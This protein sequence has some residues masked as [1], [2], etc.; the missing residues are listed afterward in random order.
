M[1]LALA[2]D[3]AAGECRF[4]LMLPGRANSAGRL[5]APHLGGSGAGV[6]DAAGAIDG[7]VAARLAAGDGAVT[8]ALSV[9]RLARKNSGNT[10]H[11]ARNATN[12]IPPPV[13]AASRP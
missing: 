1:P 4:E 10:S 9:R 7:Q 8:G 11:S 3:V 12:A 5:S 13:N 2:D 6:V